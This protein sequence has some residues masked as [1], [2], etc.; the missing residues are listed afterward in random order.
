[1]VPQRVHFWTRMRVPVALLVPMSCQV[2]RQRFP[3]R[4][5]T[6]PAVITRIAV[7]IIAFMDTSDEVLRAVFAQ[8]G[9]AL[10]HALVD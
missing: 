5:M 8:R 3:R 6:A 9:K 4:N 1:M 7:T 2:C 10:F